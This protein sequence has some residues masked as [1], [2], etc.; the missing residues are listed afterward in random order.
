MEDSFLFKIGEIGRAYFI[1][2]KNFLCL[3]LQF[4]A[5]IAVLCVRN[6]IFFLRKTYFS[7]VIVYLRSNCIFCVHLSYFCSKSQF[8]F[9]RN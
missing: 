5:L 9:G 2:K 4:C 7:S 3:K 6:N 1:Q 8:S